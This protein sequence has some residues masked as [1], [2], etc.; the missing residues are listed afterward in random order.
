MTTEGDDGSVMIEMT[1]TTATTTTTM[2]TM[3]MMI[4]KLDTKRSKHLRKNQHLN[5]HIKSLTFNTIF[6]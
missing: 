3:M 5:D 1:T 4:L 2:K 6:K